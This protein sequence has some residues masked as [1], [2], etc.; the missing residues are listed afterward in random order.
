[1]TPSAA[2]GD[3]EGPVLIAV[4]TDG[5]E[6]ARYVS[7]PSREPGAD[8]EVLPDPVGVEEARAIA[9]ACGRPEAGEELEELLSEE[10]DPDSEIESERLGRV[11]RLLGL[12]SW[13]V[14]ASSLPRH[15]PTGPPTREMT[16][17]GAG[18]PGPLGWLSGR[19][20]DVVRR[21]RRPPPALTD[22]PRADPSMNDP[23]LY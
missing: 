11:L 21:H 1:M 12:P 6:V 7:D 3:L 2:S 15:V 16:R 5:A 4:W 8:D 14:A 20:A 19:A 10:L 13:P 18:V 17:L 9:D 22:P 23:W